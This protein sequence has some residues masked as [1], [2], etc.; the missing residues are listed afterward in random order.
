MG[1]LRRFLLDAADR[2]FDEHL[3][4]FRHA[5]EQG[6]PP[7]VW[8]PDPQR[9]ASA[10]AAGWLADL[11]LED[12]EA[13]HRWSIAERERFWGRTIDRLGIVFRHAPRRILELSRGVEHA[14]WLPDARLSCVDSCFR[15]AAERPAIVT[16]SEADPRPVAVSYGG[17]ERRVNRFANALRARGLGR[18]EGVALYMPMTVECVVAYLGTIRA[19]CRVVSI[20]DSFPPA[21]VR[22]RLEIGEARLAVSVES[23]V[24]SGRTFEPY[25]R[26]REAGAPPAV[27]VG[28]GGTADL[29]TGDSAWDGFL[30]DDDSHPGVEA[31]AYDTVNVLFSSG[32]TGD[33]KAVP[34]NHLTP[35]KCAADAYFHQDVR[36]GDV[37]AWPT[38]V[39]WMMGPW[40]IWATTV[41]RATMALYDGAPNSP[42][43]ARFV[44]DAGVGVLGVVPSLVAAWRARGALDGVDWSGVRCFSSTGEPSGAEDYLWLMSRAAYRAPVVEYCGGTEIGGGYVSGSVLQ[45]CSPATFTT[46]ALG[47]DLRLLDAAGRDVAPGET[48]EAW[49]VPPS[50]GLSQSLLNRDHHEIYYAGCPRG[51]AGEVLRRHGDELTRLGGGFLRAEGRSDDTMNLGG[52]K[53]GAL[54]IERVA[55]LHRGVRECAAVGV[56][57]SGG[58]AER[59]VIFAVVDGGLDA[60]ALRAELARELAAR[61]NPLFKLHDVVVVERLPRTASNKLMR[62]EL[63]S[64]YGERES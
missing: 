9:A 20:A 33:P 62:R 18:G 29:R 8:R 16:A 7:V 38:N 26:L 35:I 52:I 61:L 12:W 48:G 41:L 56:R 3:A 55:A 43:F 13:L 17:L 47:L 58:G 28:C 46:A 5:A 44:R 24:R 39:G 30:S 2:P 36:E 63:R 25:A 59:L 19:G 23:M 64:A 50:I 53:V 37:V 57:P 10:N 11:G 34:W 42:G 27:V 45:P 49:L 22:R 15:A 4:A 51:P 54:E 14:R 40:L 21:E 1:A 60:G 31:D 6:P 32:T